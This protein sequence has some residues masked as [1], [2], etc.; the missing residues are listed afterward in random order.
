MGRLY[1]V[2]ISAV[3][4][5]A[6]TAKTIVELATGTGV[7]AN[8]VEVAIT[9]NGT[10]ATAVPVLVELIKSTAT[11]TGTAITALGLNTAVA[12][13]TTAKHTATVEGTSPTVLQAW[14]VPPTSGI[15]IQYPLGR[16]PAAL[17]SMFVGVRCTA[18]ATVSCAVNVNF[19]E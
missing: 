19:E 16:E 5:S 9:F 8:I 7:V 18:P 17:A 2:P 4:L 12:A 14:Y 1:S 13:T 10:S 3:S 6:A 11:C 15:V